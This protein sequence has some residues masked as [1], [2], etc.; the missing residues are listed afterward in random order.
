MDFH[1]YTVDGGRIEHDGDIVRLVIPPTSS[2]AYADAQLDDYDHALRRFGNGPPQ[3]LRI[4]ARFSH[5]ADALKGTAGFGFW[6]HPFTQT[7]G[8]IEPP[9]NVWFF[10]GSPES[11][12]QVARGMP[13]HGFKAAAFS[14]PL[15]AGEGQGVRAMVTRLA[16]T[17]GNLALRLPI[18]SSLAMRAAQR[19]LRAREAMLDVDITQWHDYALDWRRDETIFRIDGNEV[20]RAPKPPRGPLGFVAWIDNYRATATRNGR[21]EFG[22][23]DVPEAQFIEL[24]IENW[25][26]ADGRNLDADER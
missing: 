2:A 17:F 7:G 12:M 24:R 15:P 26:Y 9:A 16:V 14:S 5:P 3:A 10:Y 1:E 4:R 13:G 6:N 8:V 22:Y 21:Y 25:T 23:V 11:N 20:L 18:T 19:M